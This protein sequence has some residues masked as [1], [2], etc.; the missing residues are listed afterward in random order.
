M[1]G[2]IFNNKKLNELDSLSTKKIA[3]ELDCSLSGLTRLEASKRRLIYGLNTVASEGK[4]KLIW[5]LGKKILSPLVITLLI[6]AAFSYFLGEKISAIIIITMALIGIVLSFIQEYRAKKNAAKLKAMVRLHI[7]VI[8]NKKT[9]KIPLKDLVPGDVVNLYAGNM[10]PADLKII[11]TNSLFLNQSTLNGESFPM[12]KWDAPPK[13]AKPNTPIYDLPTIALMGASV[14]SGTGSGLVIATGANTEFGKLAIDVVANEPETAFDRGIRDFTWLMIKLIFV[15]MTFIFVVNTLFK[16]NFVDSLLFSLAV[17]VGLTPEMLP[18]IVT[19]NLSRGAMAMAKKMVIIKRLDSIQNFGAM[20]VLCT[21]KTGTLTM[22]EIILIKHS[23]IEGK[24][25]EEI[26]HDAWINSTFQSGL[27]NLLDRAIIK[28]HKFKKSGLKKIDEVPFDFERRIVSIII[29]DG[30]T[31]RLVA[32]GAP[33]EIIKR[34]DSYDLNGRKYILGKEKI[35]QLR[36]QYDKLSQDGFRVLAVA[37]KETDQRQKKFS[38][39]DETDLIFHGFASFLDPPKASTKEAI[40]KME[41]LGVKLKILSGDNEYVTKKICEEVGL[42][43]TGVITG[44]EIERLNKDDLQKIVEEKAIFAR[45]LPLQKERVI[46]AL[47]ENGHVVG[48]LGDGINDAPALRAADVGISVNNAADI[49]K[50]TAD[51]ILLRKSLLVLADGIKEGR[52]TFANT[53][54]YIKMGASSNFGNMLS[55]TG[56]SM[57]LPFLPMLPPQ[58]LL[59]NLMYDLS[60]IALPTDNV[61]EDYLLKPRPWHIGFIKKFILIIGPIS[62]LFDFMTYGLMWFVFNGAANPALFRTGWFVESLFT[63]TLIIYVIRTNKIPFLQSR[64]SRAI[65]FATLGVVGL[66][67]I[68]PFTSVGKLFQFQSLPGL[69]FILLFGMG[70]LYLSLTQLVKM[71]FIRKYGYE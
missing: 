65:V 51:M 6:V 21:D 29:G 28:H 7:E 25:R 62:S 53:M 26:L 54:K 5:E 1:A 64:P 37:Y 11:S 33:E 18:M 30:K 61:D 68:L 41:G 36:K 2:K 42:D 49:A 4:G 63:Q 60:Q 23:D 44:G 70:L 8:R 20:D 16:G 17:A 27:N 43:G 9:V 52:R 34:C 22:D 31:N 48:F 67:C 12:E 39:Q 69:Y 45:L 38:Q 57:I 71:L 47:Q 32:K 19:V 55:I 15:L 56:A 10:I 40:N 24:E 13:P 66:G 35:K 58:I 14:A 50:E 59:N 3:A 46:Q